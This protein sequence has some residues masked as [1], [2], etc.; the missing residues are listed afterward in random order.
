ML[1][2]ALLFLSFFLAFRYIKLLRINTMSTWV[3][4]IAYTIKVGVGF[5]FLYIYTA[6]YGNGT[7]SADAGA[8]MRESEILYKVFYS[9]PIDYF[10]LL[11]G[12][13]NQESLV[14]QYLSE[15][16]HWD[17]GAQAIISDNRNILRVQSILHFVS[18]GDSANHV[19]F[20]CFISLIGIKQLYLG[21][22]ERSLL[23]EKYLFGF[24]VLLPSVLFW[25]SGIL[26]E[27]FM[28]LGLGLFIRGV[29]GKDS[30]QKKW[31]FV[32][33]GSLF[34]LAFKPYVLFCIFPGLVFFGLYTVIPRNKTIFSFLILFLVGICITF[35]FKEQ[36][37]KV[38]HLLSR[39]QYDFKNVGKGGL[40]AQSDSCFY[41]FKPEQISELIIEGDSVSIKKEMNVKIIMHGSIDE[42]I[43]TNLLPTGEKWLIYFRNDK[44]DGFIET[45]MI[46][47]SFGQLLQNIPEALLNSLFRPFFHDPGSWLKYPAMLEILFLYMFLVFAIIKRKPLGFRDKRL[48]WTIFIF[49]I[50][51][52]LVIGWV[53]PVLGAIARYR[54]PAF[55]GILIIALMIIQ[56]KQSNE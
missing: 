15:T 26:K 8:F 31:I 1:Y 9:S 12:I 28:I 37:E 22:K 10:K 32:I 45:T 21:V 48:I 13:G 33:I 52:S 40:H 54:L 3:M 23:S 50:S 17:S 4:P 39:K 7:L 30:K 34:L 41:F 29:M 16:S 24:L 11:I 38:V 20:M 46:D 55:I 35:I 47:D 44:S 51:L 6:V 49:V 19:L 5:Y 18:R 42:P 14:A 53:T 27:P 2:T 43:N 36:R 56:P 25:T